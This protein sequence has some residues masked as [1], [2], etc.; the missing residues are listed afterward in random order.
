MNLK[1]N[2]LRRRVEIESRRIPSQHR[3]LDQ[4]YGVLASA[5]ERRDLP[6]ARSAFSHF[7]DACRA[8]FAMEDEIY[9]PALHGL[10][11]DL[12]PTLTDLVQEHRAMVRTL[13]RLASLFEAD[14]LAEG[15][16]ELDR[17]VT[18]LQAHEGREER[19]LE[20]LRSPRPEGDGT[21]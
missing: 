13:E 10:R 21:S 14:R 8:H 19:I 9:F 20:G 4:F 6:G 15:E 5:L 1:Q 17:L 3:Q 11:P 18:R 16:G 7:A 12:E 2:G